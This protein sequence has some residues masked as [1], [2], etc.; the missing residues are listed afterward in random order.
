M[1]AKHKYSVG[2]V[3]ADIFIMTDGE[4][5]RSYFS[6]KERDF[7]YL[8]EVVKRPDGTIKHYYRPLTDTEIGKRLARTGKG[9]K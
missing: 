9:S 7:C 1:K 4:S 2:Q 6:V 3:V 8:N 5:V